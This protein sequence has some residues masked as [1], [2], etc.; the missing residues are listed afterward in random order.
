M[1]SLRELEAAQKLATE[2]ERWAMVLEVLSLKAEVVLEHNSVDI[3]EKL[4]E[5]GQEAA[6]VNRRLGL[7]TDLKNKQLQVYAFCRINYHTRSEE[8]I[9]ELTKLAPAPGEVIPGSLFEKHYR[10]MSEAALSYFTGAYSQA[11]KRYEELLAV[12]ESQPDRLVTERL[13]YKRFLSNVLSAAHATGN[14]A[15]MSVILSRLKSIPTS[16]V[17]EDADKFQNLTYMELLY[18]MNTDGFDGLDALAKEIEKGLARHKAKMNKA[19]ELAFC[20]NIAMAYFLLHNWKQSLAWIERIIAQEKSEHRQDLQHTARIL[21]LVLWYE[22][23]KHDLLEYEL[24]NVERFLRKRKAWFAYESTVVKLF[25]KLPHANAAEEKAL[26]DKFSLKLA[27]AVEGKTSAALPGSSEISYWAKS[28]LSGKSM[29]EL[30]KG[31]D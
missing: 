20:H 15:F 26:V 31:G 23:G 2:N 13:I 29:R 14:F 17:E 27:E 7:L 9:A 25:T 5:I 4:E 12:W 18:L 10:M 24:I 30:L 1:L 11:M 16:S 6:D 19:R 8:K 21:R 28:K 3:A 22:L